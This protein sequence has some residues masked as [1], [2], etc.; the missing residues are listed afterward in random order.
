MNWKDFLTDQER[1]R[2]SAIPAERATLAK[3]ARRIW[4]R[5]RKRMRAKHDKAK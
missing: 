5:C 3:E 1:A 4:D 2:L